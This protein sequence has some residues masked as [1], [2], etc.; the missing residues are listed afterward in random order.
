ML[1][2]TL[3]ES[4]ISQ[5]SKKWLSVSKHREEGVQL[6]CQINTVGENLLRKSPF[7]SM[8]T[9]TCKIH[10]ERRSTPKE[11]IFRNSE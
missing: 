10:Q 7:Q 5:S 4:C 1:L 11:E 8:P 6:Q 9:S 2:Q 3:F